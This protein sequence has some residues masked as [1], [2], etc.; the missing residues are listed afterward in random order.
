MSA[1]QWFNAITLAVT[2]TLAMLLGV[3]SLLYGIYLDEVPRL[4]AEWP[5][6][7]AVTLVFTLLALA[8]AGAFFGYRRDTAW[9]IFAELGLLLALPAGAWLLYRIMG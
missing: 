9:K 5:A 8:A 7:L 6:V 4:R 2:A 3:V 1:V